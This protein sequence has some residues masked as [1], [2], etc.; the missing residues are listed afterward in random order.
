MGLERAGHVSRDTQLTGP[1]QYD[2]QKGGGAFDGSVTFNTKKGHKPTRGPTSTSLNPHPLDDPKIFGLEQDIEKLAVSLHMHE[3]PDS[4]QWVHGLEEDSVAYQQ[5]LREDGFGEH[6]DTKM[7]KES[8]KRKKKPEF[9][10]AGTWRFLQRPTPKVKH[11][12]DGKMT[13]ETAMN[14]ALGSSLIAAK[15]K[16]KAQFARAR[17]KTKH[18]NA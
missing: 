2:I 13:I 3:H 6:K 8:V 10:A 5:I 17:V 1:G 18:E 11:A 16:M 14:S 15:M 9:D 12:S 7:L 4:T